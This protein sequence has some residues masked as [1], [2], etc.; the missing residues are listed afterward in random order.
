MIPHTIR[1]DIEQIVRGAGTTLL[2][3]F[4]TPLTRKEKEAGGFVTEADL[5]SEQ[6]LIDRLQHIIP[7]AA[8]WAEESG[9]DGNDNDYCWVIDPLD[10]TTNFAHG[11]PYFCISVALT[12]RG[13]PQCGAIY[14]PL[15]NEFFY[16]QDGHGAF[17]N[18]IAIH[19]SRPQ[20][21]EECVLVVG[22]PYREDERFAPSIESIGRI[23][24]HAFA[25]RHFGAAALDLA[26]VACGRF[27][28]IFLENL[29]WW[30]IAAGILLI[31]EAGGVVTDFSGKLVRDDYK[32]CVAAS[33]PIHKVLREML[34]ST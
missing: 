21:L 1:D 12:Y 9:K 26:Y 28:A 30:D 18:D 2:S 3:Y 34:H 22:L 32:S 16:A 27:D 31:Q 7:G 19:V 4:N 5:A 6:Y 33:E 20:G 29:S 17:L 23:A 14:Q 15:L 24:P 13:V 10:G 8:F 25:F 11:L